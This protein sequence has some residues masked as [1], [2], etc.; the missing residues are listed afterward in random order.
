MLKKIKKGARK[1]FSWFL[2][3]CVI[4]FITLG[5]IF[6]FE[7]KLPKLKISYI[8]PEVALTIPE[9]KADR[10]TT[11]VTV[12]NA[13]PTFTDGP[14]ED[15]ISA[16]TSPTNYGNIVTFKATASDGESNDYWLLVCATD[17]AN[18]T[19]TGPTCGGA[20]FCRSSLTAPTNEAT[21]TT[22]ASQ[23]WPIEEVTWYAF[24]CDDHST[25]AECSNGNQGPGTD[26]S[27][28]PFVVNHGP[29]FTAITTTVDNQ[30]PGGQFTFTTTAYDLDVESTSTLRLYV[31]DNNGGATFSG[32]CVSG[33]QLCTSSGAAANASCQ[34]TDTAPTPDNAYTYYG[35]VFDSWGATSTDNP[36]SSTYTIINVAPNVGTVTLNGAANI[37][38]NIK[39]ASEIAVNASADVTDANHCNDL[40][41]ATSTIYLSSAADGP[42]CDADY[43]DCYQITGVDCGYVGCEA[44]NENDSGATLTCTTTI[45]FHAIP[46][47]AGDYLASSWFARMTGVDDDNYASSTSYTTLNGV[48]IIATEALDVTQN[49]IDYE[50]IRAGQDSGSANATTTVINFGNT[51]LDTNLFGTWMTDGLGN[52]IHSE[53][54][55]WNLTNF[56][57]GTGT[58]LSSTTPGAT[59]D[60]VINR[61][62][63]QSDVTDDIYW[64][65]GIPDGLQSGEYSGSTSLIAKIDADG[66]W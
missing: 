36:Q 9:V 37:Y 18:A 32:G 24:V 20:Q 47:D 40:T 41:T 22:T 23:A 44:G 43:N 29:D 31:C 65:I 55:E 13:P 46:T 10:A 6:N 48:E 63:S 45:A 62:T 60:V 21:C 64:G 54:Q 27:Q 42:N 30:P 39:N 7:I 59:A 34:F 56:A 15:P 4:N 5:F 53:Q 52:Y 33:N 50:I 38:L 51:P 8:K 1:P 3:I 14:K 28:S 16:T 58:E 19:T 17:S 26:G 66:I 49:Y 35:Y 12:R 57:W 25:Q 61:P 2:I 11:T